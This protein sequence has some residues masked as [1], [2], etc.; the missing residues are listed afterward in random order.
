MTTEYLDFH[1]SHRGQ[2]SVHARK[3]PTSVGAIPLEVDEETGETSIVDGSK[4]T[5]RHGARGK[6]L[7]AHPTK[8]GRGKFKAECRTCGFIISL[9][10]EKIDELVAAR[11]ALP[12]PIDIVALRMSVR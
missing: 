3:L 12:S 8:S 9:S 5:G 2:G 1:C 10:H 11:H 6:L 4:P 7:I